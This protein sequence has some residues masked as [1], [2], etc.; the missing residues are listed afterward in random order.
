[1]TQFETL[2]EIIN[3]PLFPSLSLSLS[4]SLSFVNILNKIFEDAS[5][6]WR[7]IPDYSHV[8][9]RRDNTRAFDQM[10]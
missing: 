7:N 5:C 10:N 2:M 4:L 9:E 3:I 8:I 6:S 1:M